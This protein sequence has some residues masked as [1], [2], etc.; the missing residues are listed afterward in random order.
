[1]RIETLATC[2]NRREKTLQA[3]ADLHAQE[4]PEG[5]TIGHTIVED[6]STDGTSEAVREAFPEVEIIHGD[7]GLFWAG[8]MRYGWNESVNGKSFDYLLVYNDDVKL[9][10]DTI[11]RLL[12]A[13][14]TYLG[15]GGSG[16]H[17]VVGSFMDNKGDISYGGVIRSSRLHP[18]RFKQAKPPAERYALADTTNMNACLIS[19]EALDCVGFLSEYFIHTGADYDYGLKLR[20]HGGSVVM[21]PGCI[22]VCNRNEVEASSSEQGI[23]IGERYRR[24]LGVKEQPLAQRKEYFKRY[25]GRLWPVFFLLPYFSLPFKHYMWRRKSVQKTTDSI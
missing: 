25:G 13:S 15:D 12:K 17:V 22:G 8:G 18:L 6:G 7:G 2:H 9:N 16:A 20:A 3:L 23:S 24:L 14:N 21:A 5:V 4:L 11:A 10:F 1:M 19:K